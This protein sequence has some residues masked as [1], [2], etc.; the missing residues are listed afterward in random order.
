MV[1]SS[2]LRG[3]FAGSFAFCIVCALYR[4]LFGVLRNNPD[5]DSE[6]SPRRGDFVS[7]GICRSFP[8]LSFLG[9]PAIVQRVIAELSL[10]YYKQRQ[11][12]LSWTIMQRRSLLNF[13]P[14]GPLLRLAAI[15]PVMR[16]SS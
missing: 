2:I 10:R 12:T 11:G 6:L 9:Q 14:N 4:T 5:A 13:L 3:N 15:I 1:S 7:V 16:K 8:S